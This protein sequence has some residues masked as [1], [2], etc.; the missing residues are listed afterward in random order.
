MVESATVIDEAALRR[1]IKEEV[2]RLT[3]GRIAPEDIADDEPLFSIP[4]ECDSRIELDSL[5]ALELAFAIEEA[6]GVGQPA[7]FGY[8]EVTTVARILD[9][10]RR[11][12][13]S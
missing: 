12:V 7:E 9:F 13:V 6:T 10:A 11:V 1:L 3:D 8:E 2:S 4:G 5:D